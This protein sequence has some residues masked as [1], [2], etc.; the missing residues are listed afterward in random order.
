[1]ESSTFLHEF[2][3]STYI[4]AMYMHITDKYL[5]FII[6]AQTICVIIIFVFFQFRM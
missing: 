1:M 6:K 5:F 2:H 3:I 4:F